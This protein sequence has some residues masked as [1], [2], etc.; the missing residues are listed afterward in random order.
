[1]RPH[2]CETFVYTISS[3]RGTTVVY[4]KLIDIFFEMGRSWE[5]RDYLYRR[6]L[7]DDTI[8]RF[9]LG[10]YNGFSMIPFIESGTLRNFQMR[11]DEPVKRI[12]SYYN[13]VGPLLFN[14][15][16]LKLDHT[17]YYVEGPID[18]M[19]LMQ[20]GILSISSNVGGGFNPAW[21][22][23]FLYQD[24]IYL[25]FDNDSAGVSEAKRLAKFLGETKCKIYNFQEFDEKGYDPVDFFRD[26]YTGDDFTNLVEKE[27]KYVFEI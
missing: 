7:T 1:M 2:I 18:S 11:T 5:C 9:Q 27:A 4:P 26:G 22:S 16:A 6:G 23:K 12:K 21:F 20:N 17:V 25:V 13:G 24:L 3:D 8:N 14:S 15:D 10:W 19:I